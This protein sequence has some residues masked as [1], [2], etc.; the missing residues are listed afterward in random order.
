VIRL[1]FQQAGQTA[2]VFL[3]FL[4]NQTKLAPV[5]YKQYS[6]WWI[7]C[8][9]WETILLMQAKTKRKLGVMN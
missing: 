9:L 3:F 4:K 1:T 6:C 8:E 2:K 7:A 5:V